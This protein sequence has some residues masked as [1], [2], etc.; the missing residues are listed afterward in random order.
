MSS[1]WMSA[2]MDTSDQGLS[3]LFEGPGAVV[4][5]LKGTEMRSWSLSS[6][7]VAAQYFMSRGSMHY[8]S[9]LNSL[10]VAAQ[11]IISRGSMHCQSRLNALSVAAQYSATNIQSSSP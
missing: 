1:T 6:L 10:S 4:D 9:R 8:Q 11:C 2:P 3:R 5:G 7:S